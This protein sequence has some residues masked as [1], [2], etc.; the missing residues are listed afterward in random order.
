MKRA[1]GS[2]STPGLLPS[3]CMR[4]NASRRRFP[5]GSTRSIGPKNT[6][7]K[8][9]RPHIVIAA[10][11]LSERARSLS[12]LSGAARAARYSLDA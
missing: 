9:G 2:S 4:L 5:V 10:N 7:R 11:V 6:S 3:S 8:H 12:V 1:S